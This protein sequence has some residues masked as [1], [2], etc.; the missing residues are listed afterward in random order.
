MNLKS[1]LMAGLCTTLCSAA[2]AANWP[3]WR[4][5]TGDG[6]STETNLPLRWGTNENVRW[7]VPLPEPGNST[8]VV[9]GDRV[10]V[11]Q[12]VTEGGRRTL[13]CFD[14]ANGRLLWQSGVTVSVRERTHD[15]NPY[16]SASP[17]TDGERVVCWFG[18]GGVV[19][20]DFAGKELWRKD[21][22]R[23][24]HEF[25]YGSSPVLH[26]DLVFLN[27]GPG[28]QEFLVALDKRTGREVWRHTSPTP[29]QD[30]INGTWSMP[31]IVTWQGRVELISAL[32]GELAGLDPAT[33]K[34]NWFIRP[35]GDVAKST[36]IASD[37]IVVMSWDKDF[38]EVAVRL[39][40][41]GDVQATHLLWQRRPPK[42]RVGSGVIHNGLVFGV[43][44]E[45]LMECAKL[46]T[47]EILWNERL[48]AGSANNAIW[49]SP[50]LA[51]DRLYVI[52]Q[53]GDVF[54]CRAGPKLEVLGV[55]SLREPGNSSVV[56]SNGELFLR[57]HAALWCIGGI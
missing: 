4:G 54:V 57:T 39:G 48:T 21:L 5:P 16:G 46:D 10:F 8:P 13:M 43:Q 47:G 7:R 9:W 26:G 56:P 40:G 3:A 29:G 30:D 18:S 36:P 42:R 15:T 35:A 50:V 28:K 49:S 52:N 27:F 11:T 41:T 37:G 24:D 6:I 25:G 23:H 2:T 44:R 1:I 22:G 20:Y 17:V 14:R 32:R 45:G 12:P 55:N 53:S 19:A 34:V 31:L 33:G 38:P 51:G